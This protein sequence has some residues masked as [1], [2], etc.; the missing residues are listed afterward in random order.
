MGVLACFFIWEV[1]CNIGTCTLFWGSLHPFDDAGLDRMLAM[2]SSY[3]PDEIPQCSKD[4]GIW[5]KEREPMVDDII[6]IMDRVLFPAKYT[7]K[8]VEKHAMYCGYYCVTMVNNVF[9]YGP[10]DKVF[11]AAINF[12]GS[13]ADGS[14]TAHFLHYLKGKI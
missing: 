13:W 5:V 3:C 12:S 4:D 9:A 8:K 2:G 10:N 6:G 1:R 14:L 11:F 7:D